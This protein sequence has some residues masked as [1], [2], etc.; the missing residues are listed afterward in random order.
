MV[1]YK[2]ERDGQGGA[3]RRSERATGLNLEAVTTFDG[4]IPPS[5]DQEPHSAATL[6]TSL[7]PFSAAC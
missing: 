3:E 7:K 6:G 2:A 1:G 4:L 5:P